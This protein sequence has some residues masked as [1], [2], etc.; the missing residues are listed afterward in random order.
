MKKVLKGLGIGLLAL[1]LIGGAVY[2]YV[3]INITAQVTVQ[4]PISVVSAEGAG[5]FDT[6]TSTWNIGEIYP[7]DTASIAITFAN[8]A[9]G[10]I[11]L[12]L[13]AEPASLDGGNLTFAFDS[14]TIVVPA[15]GE[16]ST[17]IT[18]STTQ[19]LAPGSYSVS[20]LIQR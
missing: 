2:A 16:A 20:I 12:S 6:A 5:T 14:N 18:A 10:P 3:A 1:M 17:G 8:A 13:S 11:T 9:S 15:G 4:E 7:Q 19:G